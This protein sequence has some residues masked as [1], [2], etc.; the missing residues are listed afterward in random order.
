M[1][2]T[3]RTRKYTYLVKVIAL[4]YSYQMKTKRL[5]ENVAH[6]NNEQ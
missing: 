5:Q 1:P 2:A 3:Q 4:H 6:K